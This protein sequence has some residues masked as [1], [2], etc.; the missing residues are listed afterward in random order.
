MNRLLLECEFAKDVHSWILKWWGIQHINFTIVHEYVNFAAS[1]RNC[2]RKRRV[3]TMI[4]YF[5]SL[6]EM[7][8]MNDKIFRRICT[9]QQKR[10]TPS[11]YNHKS[12]AS[13]KEIL[14]PVVC[15]LIL[16]YNLMS[17]LFFHAF[18]TLSYSSLLLN[19][20]V[21]SF[22]YNLIRPFQKKELDII[23]IVFFFFSKAK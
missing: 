22:G 17:F 7:D 16:I 13:T 19:V 3:V 21:F 2:P 9:P 8:G 12:G 4:F 20:C 6:E 11:L 5:D 10:H 23:S 18:C 14:G 1:W 15:L